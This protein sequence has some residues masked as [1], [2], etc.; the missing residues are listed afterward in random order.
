MLHNCTTTTMHYKQKLCKHKSP[1]L[2][3]IFSIILN[4]C[5]QFVTCGMWHCSVK[6]FRRH[7]GG[8]SMS[9]RHLE[10]SVNVMWENFI[11]SAAYWNIHILIKFLLVIFID[12]RVYTEEFG[13]WVDKHVYYIKG[14]L[15]L[16][17]LNPWFA[18]YRLLFNLEHI[19]I[20]EHV[21]FLISIVDTKLFK[22]IR[23]KVFKAEDIQDANKLGHIFTYNHIN[24]T[25][26]PKN[27]FFL[28]FIST[29]LDLCIY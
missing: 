17:Y 14:K 18:I 16:L 4:N 20:E 5:L 7:L 26:L 1:N 21:K 27:Y 9:S 29:N 15:W 28:K 3:C 10:L 11:S 19:V 23:C 8:F 22:R 2:L 25:T 13:L 24:W 12:P 6:S